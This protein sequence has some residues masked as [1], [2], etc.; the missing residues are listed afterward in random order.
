MKP[1]L[2]IY[3]ERES[4][5]MEKLQVIVPVSAFFYKEEVSDELSLKLRD[6]ELRS[7]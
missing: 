6:V 3:K 1:L 7:H 4:I 2:S 5:E